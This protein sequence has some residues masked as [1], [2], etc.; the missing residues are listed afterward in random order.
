MWRWLLVVGLVAVAVGL[1]FVLPAAAQLRGPGE[2]MA[3]TVPLL[4]FGIVVTLGGFGS[5]AYGVE[6]FRTRNS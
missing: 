3:A 2:V 1:G 4:L 5:L 6:R